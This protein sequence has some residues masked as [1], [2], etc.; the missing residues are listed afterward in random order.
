V[1]FEEETNNA[2]RQKADPK[3]A[4][5][6]ADP[7]VNCREVSTR[8]QP[9]LLG[10]SLVNGQRSVGEAI[11]LAVADLSELILQIR[12]LVMNSYPPTSR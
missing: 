4:S 2:A 1:L 6:C 8:L 10:I 7:R 12:S 9:L 11:K 3:I 5:F